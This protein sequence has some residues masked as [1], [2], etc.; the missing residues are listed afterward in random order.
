[1]DLSERRAAATLEYIVS[2]GID[3]SRLTSKGYGESMPLNECTKP[4]MCTEE[5]YA[6]NRRSE[7]KV[8]N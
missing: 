3:R 7:F 5:Q 1:M 4:D 8:M 6:K 2:K